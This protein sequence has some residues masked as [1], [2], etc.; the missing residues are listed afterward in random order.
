[1]KLS[2]YSFLV[3]DL[4]ARVRAI[5]SSGYAV[6]SR[7]SYS[8]GLNRYMKFCA[9]YDLDPLDISEAKLLRF[10]AYI[11]ALG[12][13]VS[14]IKVYLAGVRSWTVTAGFAIPVLYTPRVKLA[15]RSLERDEA[16]PSRVAPLQLATLSR[17]TLFLIPSQ[18]NLMVLAALS[19]AYFGCLRSAEYCYNRELSQGLLR[20]DVDILPTRPLSLRLTVRASKT[21]LHGFSVVLGCT[22][23]IFCPV[24]LMRAYLSAVPGGPSDPLFRFRG[25]HLMTHM[26]LTTI[27]RSVLARMGLNH[28]LYSLHSL[29]AGAATDAAALGAAAHVI[30]SLGRWRSA[31]YMAYLRPTPQAQ[32]AV[33]RF[34]ADSA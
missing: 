32:A 18:D 33:S 16:P 14:S 15:L 21:L 29:R 20:K 12:L 19:L 7:R 28:N 3:S 10:I 24:C 1:M 2:D 23:R 25:G 8:S 26:R 27:M 11:S 30:Q 6:N 5:V 34:L 31:A 17:F 13:R 9:L 22:H 4:D